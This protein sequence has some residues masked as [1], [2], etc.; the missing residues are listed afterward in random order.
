M[1]KFF[2]FALLLG[3]V[4]HV[5]AYTERNIL[6][7]KATEA[8]LKDMLITNQKWVPYPAYTDR[9]GWDKLLGGLKVSLLLC[10]A[11]LKSK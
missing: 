11:F 1:K 3:M 8:Q 7:S 9:A 10:V 6:Q 4:L 5:S 2:L